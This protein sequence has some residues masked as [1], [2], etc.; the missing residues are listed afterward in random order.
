MISENVMIQ[1]VKTNPNMV[2]IIWRTRLTPCRT[3]FCVKLDIVLP[4]A[5]YIPLYRTISAKANEL[6]H[7]HMNPV[8]IAKALNVDVRTIRRAL[9]DK[10]N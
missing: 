4:P 5:E 1:T 9:K 7:L 10:A 3:F 8:K 2:R 6:S